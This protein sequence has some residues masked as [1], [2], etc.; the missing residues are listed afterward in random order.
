MDYISHPINSPLIRNGQV[1][2]SKNS[3]SNFQIDGHTLPRLIASRLVAGTLLFSVINS[4]AGPEVQRPLIGPASAIICQTPSGIFSNFGRTLGEEAIP[5]PAFSSLLWEEKAPVLGIDSFKLVTLGDGDLSISPWIAGQEV[6]DAVVLTP[7]AKD[8]NKGRWRFKT[9]WDGLL[10]EGVV[11]GL[12]WTGGIFLP[13]AQRDE[14]NI[15]FT[16]DGELAVRYIGRTTGTFFWVF[17]MYV[18]DKEIWFIYD[19]IDT[20]EPE[21]SPLEEVSSR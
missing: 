11:A 6:S 15:M 9:S 4:C 8:C 3:L 5:T 20:T 13:A 2:R 19:S 18:Q 17:P 21:E 12:L 1:A 10:L 14:Y 16:V 7:E